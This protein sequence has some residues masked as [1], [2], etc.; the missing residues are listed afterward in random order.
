MKEKEEQLTD[1]Q[2]KYNSQKEEAEDKTRRIK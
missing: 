2:I 1:L